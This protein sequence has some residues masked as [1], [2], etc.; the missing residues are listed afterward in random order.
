MSRATLRQL[1]FESHHEGF[2]EIIDAITDEQ[3]KTVTDDRRSM[4]GS[5]RKPYAC[6]MYVPVDPVP[7]GDFSP[8]LISTDTTHDD[9]VH[10]ILMSNTG[11]GGT[12]TTSGTQRTNTK[13]KVTLLCRNKHKGDFDPGAWSTYKLSATSITDVASV[14]DP[15]AM[16][17]GGSFVHQF[18][19][20]PYRSADGETATARAMA[21]TLKFSDAQGGGETPMMEVFVSNDILPAPGPDG[22]LSVSIKNGSAKF[23]A[24]EGMMTYSLMYFTKEEK[25]TEPG[26]GGESEE[27]DERLR[28]FLTKR[29]LSPDLAEY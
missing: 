26:P 9:D 1:N 21:L 15:L 18:A 16:L 29:G 5:G 10:A 23:R 28:S 7:L 14:E 8:I 6:T 27:E 11:T 2:G 17:T 22:H 25:H 19:R 20:K 3:H 13:S 4:R 24:Q 12:R